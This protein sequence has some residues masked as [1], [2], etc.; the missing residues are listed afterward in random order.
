MSEV[1]TVVKVE[2]ETIHIG[3]REF[4]VPSLSVRQAKK[5]W[6]SILELDKGITVENLPEK[7]ELAIPII[8]AALSRNYP[9]LTQDELEDLVDV[10]NLR[11][12]LLVVSGQSGIK[13]K[14]G[15]KVPV[16]DDEEVPVVH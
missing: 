2:G 10:K 7:Y 15:E 8:H 9:D 1:K 4:V 11:Q 16:A 6:P 14:P 12:L 3:G 5:L 13:P